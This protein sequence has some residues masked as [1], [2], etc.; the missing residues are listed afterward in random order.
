MYSG[1]VLWFKRLQWGLEEAGIPLIVCMRHENSRKLH[2]LTVADSC[3]AAVAFEFEQ[4]GNMGTWELWNPTFPICFPQ[5]KTPFIQV[6]CLAMGHGCI[7]DTKLDTG[8]AGQRCEEAAEGGV[9][10]SQLES[11]GVRENGAV[12]DWEMALKIRKSRVKGQWVS[13]FHQVLSRNCRRTR[14]LHLHTSCPALN[15]CGFQHGHE[16]CHPMESLSRSGYPCAK[17]LKTL[18]S[19]VSKGNTIVPLYLGLSTARLVPCSLGS[20]TEEML[21]V[22]F[23]ALFSQEKIPVCRFRPLVHDH[24]PH[25]NDQN[26][27]VKE[28]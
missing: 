25:L 15:H 22:S 12:W 5:K 10:W 21:K 16:T 23:P 17:A 8:V 11:D 1:S 4:H 14:T 9:N 24:F 26:L 7:S 2:A 28:M 13:E 19:L 27:R 18:Q 3:F 20:W 6:R